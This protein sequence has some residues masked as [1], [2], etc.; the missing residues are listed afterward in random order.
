MTTLSRV[1]SIDT[2]PSLL[3]SGDRGQSVQRKGSSLLYRA[4]LPGLA[5]I[6]F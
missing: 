3:E 1:D 2:Q 4:S 5:Y 6:S